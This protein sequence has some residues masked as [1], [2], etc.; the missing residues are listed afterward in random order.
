MSEVLQHALTVSPL[1]HHLRARIQYDLM[2]LFGV[3]S[4]AM[5]AGKGTQYGF[6]GLDLLNGFAVRYDAN[7]SGGAAVVKTNFAERVMQMT[8]GCALAVVMT[9]DEIAARSFITTKNVSQW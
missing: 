6:P 9:Y 7:T 3:C 4:G 8:T 5:M 2:S 1:V